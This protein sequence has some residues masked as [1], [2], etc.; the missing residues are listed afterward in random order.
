MKQLRSAASLAIVA[1][2]L[3][4]KFDISIKFTTD[5]A[6]CGVSESGKYEIGIPY[7]TDTS[8]GNILLGFL[9]H[10]I[11]HAKFTDF[12]FV[13]QTGNKYISVLENI[14]EDIWIESKLEHVYGG[15]KYYLDAVRQHV[16]TEKPINSVISIEEKITFFI[17][18][19][20]LHGRSKY[21]G[22]VVNNINE[23]KL[24]F[25]SIF[26]I[27]ISDKVDRLLEMVLLSTT[28]VDNNLIAK[29]L[30]IVL[31][32]A[33]QL[34]P[35][36][37]L[38][39]SNG[40][41]GDAGNSEGNDP[42]G[43]GNSEGNDPDGSGNSEGNDPDGSGNSEGNDPDGSGSSE[44]NDPDGSGNSEGND[45]DG[46][47][48][49]DCSGVGESSNGPN[50]VNVS[51]ETDTDDLDSDPESFND[52]F[53]D[54]SFDSV[55]ENV[56]QD[57]TSTISN[58]EQLKKDMSSKGIVNDFFN[59]A[60]INTEWKKNFNQATQTITS[61]D[62]KRSLNTGCRLRRSFEKL[63]HD[64]TTSTSRLKEQGARIKSSK[65][66]GV[67]TG[68]TNIFKTKSVI[69]SPNCACS[70]LLDTSSSM[71][72]YHFDTSRIRAALSSVIA[73]LE[74]LNITGVS[75]A[76]YAFPFY[77]EES[78]SLLVQTMKPRYTPLR[79]SISQGVFTHKGCLGSTPLAE[80]LIP[81]ISEIALSREKKKMI[82]IITDGEPNDD[83]KTQ[84]IINSATIEGIEVCTFVL[85]EDGTNEAYFKRIFGKNTIFINKFNEI[86]QSIL[87]MCANLIVTAR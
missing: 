60:I 67:K 55:N 61:L 75:T 17:N 58:T 8:F 22:V 38:P 74:G 68:N 81:V 1:N 63:V 44:G 43:S 86:E 65:L 13:A 53:K 14:C 35:Q 25:I 83:N 32:T 12:S 19:V 7:T 34:K 71:H 87:Q 69:Q 50:D 9:I 57:I 72:E 48:N 3:A 80:S 36:D 27:A 45:P 85:N 42:D 82:F 4:G 56:I 66:A 70:I 59:V 79:A 26:T 62:I 6:Y 77:V 49:S 64:N 18:Y 39:P 10:E 47:G 76:C 2:V 54:V 40:S 21:N 5:E 84:E 11:G 78:N 73:V 31:A 20:L 33:L 37:T 41:S 28:T 51:T 46:S 24:Q 52:I 16:F 29:K 23:L 30:F 15:A